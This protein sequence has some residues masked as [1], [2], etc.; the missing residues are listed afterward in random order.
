MKKPSSPAA[1][2]R[3]PLTRRSGH[4]RPNLE[5][6]EER[7]A[8]TANILVTTDGSF[9]QQALKEFTP[10][11]ALVRSVVVPPGGAAEDARD[12]LLDTS[13][14]VLIYNGTNDPYLSTYNLAGGTWAHRT[15]SGWSTTNNVSY[16]GVGLW[17]D[18]AFATDMRTYSETADQARGIIRFNRVDGS[19]ARFADTLDFNDL[20]VGHDGLLYALAWPRT[21]Y[22]YNPAT[23]A[24]VR[25]VGLPSSINGT[26]QDYRGIA[27]NAAG[28]I[29]AATWGKQ[30]HRFDSS[31]VVQASVTLT[32]PGGGALFSGLTD[33]DASTDGQLV[34]GSFFGHVVQM[35]AAFT[36]VTYFSGGSSSVFVAFGPDGGPPPPPPQSS[37]S[38]N[39]VSVNE[40]H[41]GTTAATFTI[42]LSAASAETVT[43]NYA[44]A[45]GTATAGS[46]YTAGSGTLTFAPGETSKTVTVSIT[47]DTVTESNETFTV[48]LSGPT[49]ATLGDGQGVATIV[50]DD[51]PP[52]LRVN[53]VTVT[54]GNSG[55]VT[56]VFTVTLT[57]AGTQAVTVNWA[58]S[59]GSAIAGYDYTYASGTLSFAP[60]ETSKTVSVNVTGDVL[61]ENNELLYLNL[62]GA[63]NAT[64]SDSWGYGTIADDDAE[65]AVSVNIVSVTEGH[66]GSVSAVFTLSLS[67]ASGRT[68]Y[69]YW[70]TAN[71]TAVA[72]SDYV[73]ASGTAY[74]YAGQTS[75][76]VS[77]SVT[78]DTVSE[79]DE[80]F[81]LNL[82]GAS[83]AT[84]ADNQGV[85]TIADDDGPV[86]PDMSI[87]DVYRTEGT[88]GTTTASVNVSLSAAST[89]TVTVNWATADGTATAGSDYTAANGTLTFAPGETS[90][91]VSVSVTGDNWDEPSETFTVN[92]S[93]A[94]YANLVDGTGVVSVGDDDFTDIRISDI[95]VAEGQTGTTL[96]TFTVSLS[97]PSAWMLAVN[98]S[99][100]NDTATA[101]TDYTAA[102]GTVTFNPGETSKP[103]TVI[104]GGD[105]A[106]E[107]NERFFVNISSPNGYVADGQGIGTIV[108]DD[109]RWELLPVVTRTYQDFHADGTNTSLVDWGSHLNVKR[110]STPP[111]S[112]GPMDERALLEYDL[113]GVT[114]AGVGDALLE[115]NVTY[116]GGS[117][118]LYVF[119]Y[120][121]DGAITLADGTASGVLL[122]TIPAPQAMGKNYLRLDRDAFAGLLATSS[123]VGLRI[124]TSAENAVWLSGP[125]TSAPRLIVL[126]STFVAPQVSIG[127]AQVVEGNKTPHLHDGDTTVMVPIT[128]SAQPLVPVTVTYTTYVHSATSGDFVTRTGT[129][130]F[131]PGQVSGGALMQAVADNFIEGDEAF[132]VRLSAPQYADAAD[133]EA[134]VT[135]LDNDTGPTLAD[136]GPDATVVAGNAAFLSADWSRV[137]IAP[138]VT[139]TWDLGDGITSSRPAT[140]P[141]AFQ[142][143]RFYNVQ[144]TYTAS[145]TI[146]DPVLGNSTDTATVYVTNAAPT[147]SIAGPDPVAVGQ[148]ATW[149]FTVNDVEADDLAAGLTLTVQWDDGTS[150]TITTTTPTVTLSHTYAT[151]DPAYRINATVT[152]RDNGS[153]SA[154][155][156]VAVRHAAVMDGM[157][158]LAGTAGNDHLFV[159]PSISSGYAEVY[160]GGAWQGNFSLNGLAGV[161]VHGY[162]GDDL[163]EVVP[164]GTYQWQ[165]WPVY[166]FGGEGND[167]INVSGSVAHVLVGGDGND[168]LNGGPG[169]DL[170]VGGAG[171]DTL[172]GNGGSD[173][174]IGGTTVYDANVSA[175]VLL[176]LEWARTDVSLQSKV[177]HLN[178]TVAGG[179]N[180]GHVLMASTVLDDAALDD[181]WGGADTDWF[182]TH[183]GSPFVDQKRDPE[184]GEFFSEL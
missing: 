118:P 113:A 140:D 162:G 71:G 36:N 64:I 179:H 22:V 158:I 48:N 120:A 111:V 33:I 51:T 123:F 72:G 9:P 87:A 34:L 98:W 125:S 132:Y 45:D 109:V 82:T 61:D 66:S 106:D 57:P 143:A 18:Y 139:L 124:E 131:A 29:F 112:G 55:P 89:Q 110:V 54:E 148:Q 8:P 181:L 7:L 104:L 70:S 4:R 117:Q 175:L 146:T 94:V 119:G 103:I 173:L 105:R 168:V 170:L 172:Y 32:G 50:N 84:I 12:L 116:V 23:M 78:G 62:S 24:L 85:G 92:L 156:W 101:G 96:A 41:S 31:G 15:H 39:D 21:V 152:D 107:G 115:Y 6:L 26:S 69:V 99:T 16:G 53:D 122:G 76:T 138:D 149:T 46:D 81:F 147:V 144:G 19:S 171:N 2:H 86:T 49:N 114:P 167:T 102:S 134:A 10:A 157:L 130:T 164:N 14:N 142:A 74:I 52:S 180:G 183:A 79:A 90:K 166:L 13:G 155:K 5:H 129:V 153:G 151:T 63:V 121:G 25:S 133:M 150:D 60:G 182:F 176:R 30:V 97:V 38:V 184:A 67:A 141:N 75:K 65:P 95:S 59:N 28:E 88:G 93:G 1:R 127:D 40:G 27:V 165:A 169:G 35:T 44:T 73:S 77:V 20:T 136:A 137:R 135:I 3:S 42:T 37:L 128:L 160:V 108:N 145:L 100:S 43:V 178:G 80:T 161:R 58:T 83:Y 17:G 56:A 126:D 174:L 47:G 177:D 163:L 91:A 154:G 159:R 68:V 11:G